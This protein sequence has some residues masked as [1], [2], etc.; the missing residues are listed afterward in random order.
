[1][2]VSVNVLKVKDVARLICFSLTGK[3]LSGQAISLPFLLENTYPPPLN[4]NFHHQKVYRAKR[5]Y[6]FNR[7]IK[8]VQYKFSV[9]TAFIF[10]HQ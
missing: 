3:L 6:S 1:M 10:V 8:I 4:I 2:S 7:N 9:T 5:T